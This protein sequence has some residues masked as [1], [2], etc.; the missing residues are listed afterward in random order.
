[1]TWKVINMED[2]KKQFILLWKTNKFTLSQLCRD[3]NITRPTGYKILKRYEEEGWDALNELSRRHWKHPMET[4]KEMVDAILEIRNKY[5]RYSGL[6]I[7]NSK[8]A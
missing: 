8:T 5:P 4:P 3:F 7:S 1:M 2:Q 6:K